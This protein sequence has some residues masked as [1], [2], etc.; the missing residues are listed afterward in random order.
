MYIIIP[1]IFSAITNH[2]LKILFIR[3]NKIVLHLELPNSNQKQKSNWKREYSSFKVPTYIKSLWNF[4]LPRVIV[5]VIIL[6]IGIKWSS[7]RNHSHHSQ[8]MWSP[9]FL[10]SFQGHPLLVYWE[11]GSSPHLPSWVSI[12]NSVVSP[13]CD[14]NV[15]CRLL[16]PLLFSASFHACS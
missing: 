9:V 1:I 6:P 5:L 3:E 2:N 7:L 14:L 4:F 12:C 16:W 11:E 10:T 15:C 8:S 13:Q